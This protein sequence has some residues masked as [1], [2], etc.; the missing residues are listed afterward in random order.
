MEH[1]EGKL[2]AKTAIVSLP[3]ALSCQ[4]SQGQ[5]HEFDRRLCRHINSSLLTPNSS[6][7]KAPHGFSFFAL[8]QKIRAAAKANFAA[9]RYLLDFSALPRL[10]FTCG[11]VEH[12]GDERENKQCR[13][14][15]D[16]AAGR[17]QQHSIA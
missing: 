12:G 11:Y 6:L 16:I 3:Q 13:N 7:Y 4:L 8:R 2:L 17:R 1:D 10:R 14:R 9:A 15:N 5:S